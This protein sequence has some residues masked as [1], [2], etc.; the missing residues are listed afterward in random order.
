[1]RIG[2]Q[3]LNVRFMETQRTHKQKKTKAMI[4]KTAH[5]GCTAPRLRSLMRLSLRLVPCA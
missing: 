4:H 1:M 5:T 2:I 3:L